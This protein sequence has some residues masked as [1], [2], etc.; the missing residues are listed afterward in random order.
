MST[1]G[2][3][4]SL[5]S[6]P[7]KPFFFFFFLFERKKS[8][9]IELRFSFRRSY[10]IMH[11]HASLLNGIRTHKYYE[12]E[13]DMGGREKWRYHR[14]IANLYTFARIYSFNANK[15]P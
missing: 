4:I 2:K 9:V 6:R 3:I 8:Q 1:F 15:R 10:I 7:L 5:G 12:D 11:T 14:I 13:D